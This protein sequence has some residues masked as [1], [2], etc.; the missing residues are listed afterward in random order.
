MH[1]INKR[2]NMS[3]YNLLSSRPAVNML[4]MLYDGEVVEKASYSMNLSDIKKNMRAVS[5]N[6]MPLNDNAFNSAANSAVVILKHSELITADDIDDDIALS[7]TNKGKEFIEL[8]DQLIELSN[9]DADINRN[10]PK[11]HIAVKYGLTQQEKKILALCY[12]MS[13]ESGMEYISLKELASE[14][15]PRDYKKK[16]SIIARDIN[17]LK[18]LN[19]MARDDEAKGSKKTGA[20]KRTMVKVTDKGF[21]TIKEQ[22]LKGVLG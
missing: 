1:N 4:K 19:L 11:K 8:F 6:N 5:G 15:F 12:K 14:L 21:K 3:L 22:Y 13:K 10:N 2:D 18:E 9:P 17:K 7:I 16:L 20:K